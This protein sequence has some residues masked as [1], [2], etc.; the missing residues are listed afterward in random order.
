MYIYCIPCK[1]DVVH[2]GLN[3]MGLSQLSYIITPALHSSDFLNLQL[4][5]L[6]GQQVVTY[7]CSQYIDGVVTLNV[8]LARSVMDVHV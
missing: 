2:P 6:F 4:E 7:T 8:E 1:S 3:I 5:T